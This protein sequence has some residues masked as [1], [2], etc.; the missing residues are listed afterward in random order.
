MKKLFVLI[1][2][3]FLLTGC[4]ASIQ[5][6]PEQFEPKGVTQPIWGC[7]DMRETNPEADC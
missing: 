5:E 4:A 2:M 3:L 1:A 7:K 6:V